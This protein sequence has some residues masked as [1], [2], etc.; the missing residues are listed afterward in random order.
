M[1][2]IPTCIG[3]LFC[4]QLYNQVEASCL[5]VMFKFILAVCDTVCDDFPRRS[6][7]SMIRKRSH[8]NTNV[9]KKEK[10]PQQ[11]AGMAHPFSSHAGYLLS[12]VDKAKENDLWVQTV[13]KCLNL[14]TLTTAAFVPAYSSALQSRNVVVTQAY[15]L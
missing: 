12:T 3:E 7:M 14:S 13:I 4:K 2:G 6:L 15:V 5:C 8:S 10:P 9:S 11:E 1:G